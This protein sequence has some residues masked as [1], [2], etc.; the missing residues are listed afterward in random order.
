MYLSL[1]EEGSHDMLGLE[2]VL[3][4]LSGVGLV[5]DVHQEEKKGHQKTGQCGSAM[6]SR[7]NSRTLHLD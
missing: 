7:L 4:D 2:G 5:A 6:N 3:P 1:E